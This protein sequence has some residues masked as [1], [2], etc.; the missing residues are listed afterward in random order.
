LR[1]S[2]C[3]FHPGDEIQKTVREVVRVW[4]EIGPA[5]VDEEFIAA[6]IA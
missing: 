3:L 5:G 1:R 6:I 4:L 2:A